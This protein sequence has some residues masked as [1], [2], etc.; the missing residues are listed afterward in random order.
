[1]EGWEMY[2]YKSKTKLAGASSCWMG[3]FISKFICFE[4]TDVAAIDW[5]CIFHL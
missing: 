5:L 1:M 3:G 2:R 4:K